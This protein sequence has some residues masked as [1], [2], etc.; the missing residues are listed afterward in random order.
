MG[1]SNKNN[2]TMAAKTTNKKTSKKG[3]A[4][5]DA[6]AKAQS[7]QSRCGLQFPVTRIKNYMN[8]MRANKTVTYNAAVCCSAVLEH[9]CAEVTDIAIRLAVDQKKKTFNQKHLFQAVDGDD[10]LRRVFNGLIHEGG[11]RRTVTDFRFKSQ[12]Q[13]H[14]AEKKAEKDASKQQVTATM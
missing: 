9:L 13:I 14:A 1:I 3:G 12:K 4:K 6:K 2:K 10:E 7:V 8:R 5:K 11:V